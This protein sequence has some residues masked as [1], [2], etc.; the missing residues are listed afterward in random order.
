M[1]NGILITAPK[2]DITTEYLAT[3]SIQIEK[4]CVK[5][6]IFHKSLKG[7]HANKSEFLKRLNTGNFQTVFMNGHGSEDS[8][9]G[10]KNQVLI[11]AGENEE[12]LKEKIIYARSCE[13][14]S[15]LGKKVT[16]NSTGC[17]IG[18]ILPFE[19]Y[20]DET[21]VTNPIKDN[22]ARLFLDSSNLV[23][24]S[25]IKG[26]STKEAHERA[27]KQMLKNIKK[28]LRDKNKESF[29]IAESLWNNY[30]G[31]VILGNSEAKI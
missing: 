30:L 16:E 4:T 19:F 24:L 7:E 25:L 13:A 20:Y 11:K 17:F 27:K 15:I 9:S 21:W 31:Q 1:T 2:H 5:N 26:N 3:F 29:V 6:G 8:I 18:Y 23:P 10:H 22:I 28:V 14:A 12:V